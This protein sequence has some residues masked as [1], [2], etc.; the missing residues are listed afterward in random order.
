[1]RSQRVDS[2]HISYNLNISPY[3][4]LIMAQ[5]TIEVSDALLSEL[6]QIQSQLSI[7]LSQWAIIQQN[8]QA[9]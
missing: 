7:L 9:A 1:M 8:A 5:L 2:V 4:P 6:E 3:E